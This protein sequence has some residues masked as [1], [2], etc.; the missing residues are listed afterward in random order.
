MNENS[1]TN[2]YMVARTQAMRDVADAEL[3]NLSE[4]SAKNIPK[5]F[6]NPPMMKELTVRPEGNKCEI[7]WHDEHTYWET[8]EDEKCDDMS[9]WRR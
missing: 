8:C 9:W 7:T 2:V 1:P 3:S 6:T 5:A 4:N